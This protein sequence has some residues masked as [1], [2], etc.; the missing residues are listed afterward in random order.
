MN[1][2]KIFQM[3]DKTIFKKNITVI[4]RGGI[5]QLETPQL[6]FFTSQHLLT[7]FTATINYF[8]PTNGPI[9]GNFTVTN[10]RENKFIALFTLL[11]L[12]VQ[13][14]LSLLS[15]FFE[16]LLQ[17]PGLRSRSAMLAARGAFK[18]V[19]CFLHHGNSKVCLQV[20]FRFI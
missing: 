8:A 14:L 17:R 19:A 9:T 15:G 2:Y 3:K 7:F 6:L 5:F 18:I 10:K 11:F 13:R 4:M 1:E 16:Q 20:H 12:T